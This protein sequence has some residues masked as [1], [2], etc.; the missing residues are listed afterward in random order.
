MKPDENTK[1]I[2]PT[3][4]NNPSSFTSVTLSC[5]KYDLTEFL[6]TDENFGTDGVFDTIYQRIQIHF[7]RITR[8]STDACIYH[9]I[10]ADRL[11]GLVT[12]FEGRI[13]IDNIIENVGNIYERNVPSSDRLIEF[14]ASYKFTES[15]S[16]AGSG[17]FEGRLTIYMTM[18]EDN[19]LLDNMGEYMGDGFENFTY[20]GTWQNHNMGRIKQCTWGQ[21][22]LPNT[23]DFDVGA[24][25]LFVNDKYRKNGWEMDENNMNYL[26]NPKKWWRVKDSK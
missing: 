13:Q 20:E 3:N 16:K 15:V 22:R 18:N 25:G 12:P 24:G 5:L 26:D 1:S 11:K 9:I 6:Y 10:G 14:Y 23:K 8:D 7:E 4:R 21:G 17:I 2:H 19:K